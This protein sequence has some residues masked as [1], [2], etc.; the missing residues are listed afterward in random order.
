VKDAGAPGNEEETRQSIQGAIGTIPAGL[1]VIAAAAT[2]SIEEWLIPLDE[3][4]QLDER[5]AKERWSREFRTRSI[6][7]KIQRAEEVNLAELRGFSPNGF[8]L[9]VRSMESWS[10]RGDATT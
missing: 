10:K 5:Q 6:E 3:R 2:P 9:L 7:R 8:D 4:E 1:H